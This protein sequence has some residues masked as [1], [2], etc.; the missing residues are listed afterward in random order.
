MALK[1]HRMVVIFAGKLF[2]MEWLLFRNPKLIWGEMC[3]LFKH[4]IPICTCWAL[5]GSSNRQLGIRKIPYP[6]PS[7][8]LG[9]GKNSLTKHFRVCRWYLST[10]KEWLLTPKIVFPTIL[11]GQIL[12]KC[13]SFPFMGLPFSTKC[14]WEL[15]EIGPAIHEALLGTSDYSCFVPISKM[16]TCNWFSK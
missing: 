14:C 15:I 10:V 6:F 13:T 5:R 16:W 12:S 3:I 1:D 2:V 11:F 9:I 4:F 7:N 8:K